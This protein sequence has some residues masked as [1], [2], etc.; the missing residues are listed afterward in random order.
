[1]VF[2]RFSLSNLD[3]PALNNW[4]VDSLLAR[5]GKADQIDLVK[6]LET[7]PTYSPHNVSESGVQNANSNGAS[8]ALSY[9]VSYALLF[10]AFVTSGYLMASIVEEKESRMIEIL[11]SSVRPVQLLA[12]KFLALSL[13]GLIQMA[14]WG[15][16]LAFLLKQVLIVSPE[17]L[18]LQLPSASQIGVMI[19]YFL[20]G[21]LLLAAFYA[22]IGALV[23]NMREGPQL[24]TFITLPFI[25][26]LY[27]IQIISSA[28]NGQLAVILSIFPITAPM[29]MI[30]RA[31]LTNVPP[32]E[33][34]I[35]AG[36]LTLTILFALWL[37]GRMFRV[38][39]LL[40]GQLPRLRDLPR[41]LRE[42]LSSA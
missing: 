22:S 25:A 26:P 36:L 6:R 13:L 42:T 32:G 5:I 11:L 10:S 39:T 34:A 14:C 35:S 16:T 19:L 41:L 37:A 31:A 30:T 2:D 40:S 21:Y 33:I 9:I 12:G 38:S 28:P 17:M 15:L 27:A 29:T 24:A 8:F 23:T 7:P 1:M 18:G 4:I 3:T 20:L